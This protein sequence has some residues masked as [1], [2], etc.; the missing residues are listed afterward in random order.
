MDMQKFERGTLVRFSHCDPAGI[1]FFPQYL[2]LFHQHVEDWF[3]QCLEI[4]YA[5]FISRRRCGIPTVKLECE[6]KAPSRMG[7]QVTLSLGVASI[8]RS[9]LNLE[10]AC[11]AGDQVRVTARQTLVITSLDTDRAIPIPEDLLTQLRRFTA[12]D[13]SLPSR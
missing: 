12:A 1:V 13:C 5:D 3:N 4:N 8:G 7:E 9:S 11:R 6:F 2:V 10:L